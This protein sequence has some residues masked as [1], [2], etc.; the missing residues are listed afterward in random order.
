MPYIVLDIAGKWFSTTEHATSTYV[1]INEVTIG[2]TTVVGNTVTPTFPV[3]YP[4]VDAIGGNV[5]VGPYWDNATNYGRSNLADDDIDFMYAPSF[6]SFLTSN[7]NLDTSYFN[8]TALKIQR[9]PGT[10]NIWVGTTAYRLPR[11]ITAYYCD[12]FTVADNLT[13]RSNAGLILIGTVDIPST[14]TASTMFTMGSLQTATLNGELVTGVQ[15]GIRSKA[16]SGE[17]LPELA[18]GNASTRVVSGIHVSGASLGERSLRTSEGTYL[19][20]IASGE[21]ST[22]H[23]QGEYI[24]TFT[25][26]SND[27]YLFD[28]AVTPTHQYKD[29]IVRATSTYK[30]TA[31]LIGKYNVTIGDITFIDNTSADEDVSTVA[32]SMQPTDLAAGV[33]K[34][35]LTYFLASGTTQYLDFEVFK[36]ASKRSLAIRTFKDYDGGYDGGRMNPAPSSLSKDGAFLVPKRYDSTVIYSTVDT[37]IPLAGYANII[38]TNI[39]ASGARTLVSFDNR[40]TWKSYMPISYIPGTVDSVPK[41]LGYSD[42]SVVISASEELAGTEYAAW[43]AFNDYK[44]DYG[45]CT[46]S[47]TSGWLQVAYAEHKVVNSYALSM[48]V[49][50]TYM[51][52]NWTFEGSNDGIAWSVLDTQV[53]QSTWTAGVMV[54]YT[55]ANITP[56]SYYRLNISA[57]NGGVRII[58]LEAEFLEAIPTVYS[59]QSVSINDISL[60]GMTPEHV[61]SMTQ[62]IW[63]A[64]FT[65][66]NLDFAVYLDNKLTSYADVKSETLLATLRITGGLSEYTIPDGMAVTQVYYNVGGGSRLVGTYSRYGAE[67]ALVST[68]VNEEP[69]VGVLDFTDLQEGKPIYF[70]G[71]PPSGGSGPYATVDIYGAPKTA[72]LN[73]ITVALPPNTPPTVTNIVLT[74]D[75]THNDDVVL[76]ADI[77]DAE[78][79]DAYYHI[80]LNGVPLADY[81]SNGTSYSISKTIPSSLLPI[82]TSSI[83]IETYD[84]DMHGT[85]CILYVTRTD[86]IPTITGI[87]TGDYLTATI[88]D[89]DND[90]VKYRILVNGI[91]KQDWS[92]LISPPTTVS[93]RIPTQD[94]IL[95][96]Q[97]NVTIE[98]QDNLG[99]AG[100]CVFDFVGQYCGLMFTDEAGDYYSD[101]KG[102]TLKMLDFGNFLIKGA[103]EIKPV[104]IKNTI[105]GDSLQEVTV[106]VNNISEEAA[107]LKLSLT[108]E[109]FANIDSI[110]LP[111]SLGYNDTYTIYVRASSD[112]EKSVGNNILKLSVTA[113][114]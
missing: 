48:R 41:M 94:I 97:N 14:T 50:Y 92:E 25:A 10:V 18:S 39:D 32:F 52:K 75:T 66:S 79:D 34:C 71:Y 56:Y 26:D 42:S 49:S 68:N 76:T 4:T 101:D 104:I 3:E 85:S 58:I 108:K 109:S 78:G 29:Q 43:N 51:P 7:D 110:V 13:A 35:R 46:S 44:S 67:V 74:P 1:E 64:E 69:K 113:K 62:D 59:W 47:A 83:N 88:G 96:A 60:L 36:E 27:A 80:V 105:G 54:T 8:R 23:Y 99:G 95:N 82:G 87:L 5:T 106:S 93:Y 38:S 55:F 37:H 19:P 16:I 114:R 53:D 91:V 86:E 9:N 45:W 33:N 20:I 2:P 90:S 28:L 63:D 57:N 24:R 107:D 112:K 40:Q 61:N 77:S 65:P 100:S 17:R 98:V 31:T 12:S 21:R 81:T 72:Y 103:S 102:E 89:T 11:Q 22:P 84:G 6:T 70:K 15:S 111:V 30:G 73:S